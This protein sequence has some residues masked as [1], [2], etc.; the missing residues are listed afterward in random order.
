M[1]FTKTN[2]LNPHRALIQLL[3]LILLIPSNAEEA[4]PALI[5]FGSQ[6]SGYIVQQN[7]IEIGNE[8]TTPSLNL[9]QYDHVFVY[10]SQ[11]D[12]PIT[13]PSGIPL[14]SV[15]INVAGDATFIAH[16]IPKNQDT[17]SDGLAD[18]FEYRKFGNLNQTSTGDRDSDGYNNAKELFLGQEVNIADLVEDGG[19]SF[20][21]SSS[22]S[23]SDPSL[24]RVNIY[25]NPQGLID[26]Q[27]NFEPLNTEKSTSNLS[28]AK[29][30]YHFLIGQSTA[31]DK[32]P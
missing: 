28:G 21:S 30:G 10:W 13:D 16:F 23:Y 5:K 22:I 31:L 20:S 7:V 9:E 1:V 26:S 17:D 19:I 15:T 4:L 3:L 11:G 14:L 32:P 27:S 6:P 24:V 8:V 29:N 12:G 18:W 25:S 2:I